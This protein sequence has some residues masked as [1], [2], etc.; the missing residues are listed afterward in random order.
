MRL[1]LP[2]VAPAQVSLAWTYS[3]GA[4]DPMAWP[5]VPT[6]ADAT[7]ALGHDGSFRLT[8]PGDWKAQRPTAVPGGP[9]GVWSAV[10]PRDPGS[11]RTDELFWIGLGITNPAAA[12][13]TVGIDRIL[14]N[15]APARTA[16][17]IRAPEILGEGTG[18]A[19]QVLELRNRP[20]FRRPGL[21]APYGDLE[22]QL[23]VGTPPAWT[24]WTP[25]D[26]FPPGPGEFYRVD[27]VVGEISFGNFDPQTEHRTGVDPAGGQ[28]DQGDQL[29]L[30]RRGRGRQRR[31]PAGSSPSGRPARRHAGRHHPPSPTSVPVGT[32]PT[33]SRSRTTLRR[34]PEQLQDPR[35][36]GDRRRLRVPGQGGHQR[37]PDQPLPGAA[38]ADGARAGEPAGVAQGRP[39]DLRRHRPRPRNRQSDHRAGPGCGR[40]PSGADPGPDPAGPRL[41]GAAPG[42]DRP[43]RGPGPPVP[44]GGGQ[45]GG[46]DLAAGHR[47]RSGPEQGEGGHARPDP[48][49]PPPHPRWTRRPGMG[50]R[51][52][53]LHLGSLPGDHARGGP[54]VH[55]QPPGAAGHPR[56]PL[57]PDQPRRHLRQLPRQLERPFKLSPLGASVRLADYELVC[58]AAE[59]IFTPIVQSI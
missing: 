10:T 29:P 16:I 15:A 59:H 38:P 22:V 44:A 48:P 58:A 42:P 26:D 49:L 56:V 19:F 55:L 21:E 1:Y 8:V 32:A 35:P 33:R 6:V 54:R 39:V 53:R 18:Q 20:L 9:A 14:F 2:V 40:G 28:R 4:T 50:G 36:G 47:R 46:G 27:P 11:A 30:R 34:A 12:S 41:P 31:P 52:A 25:V 24:T 23:G 45:R 13:L 43:P 5:A 7:D 37:R 17:T 51:P 3:R 57:P